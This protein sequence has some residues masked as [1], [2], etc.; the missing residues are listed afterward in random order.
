MPIATAT[1]KDRIPI[2][3]SRI[4]ESSSGQQNC[5]IETPKNVTPLSRRESLATTQ[6]SNKKRRLDLPVEARPKNGRAATKKS[7]CRFAVFSVTSTALAALAAARA[8]ILA[9]TRGLFGSTLNQQKTTTETFQVRQNVA[10]KD[11]NRR[12]CWY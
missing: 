7:N 3:D 10:R 2:R 5:V 1:A 6:K 8:A 9:A 11:F 12:F 4:I